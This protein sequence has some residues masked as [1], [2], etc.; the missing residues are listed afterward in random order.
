MP[1]CFLF[2]MNLLIGRRNVKEYLQRSSLVSCLM[3]FG[4][5]ERHR[6]RLLALLHWQP[7]KDALASAAGLFSNPKPAIDDQVLVHGVS[8]VAS[9]RKKLYFSV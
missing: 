6:V 7:G 4:H 8:S 2:T 9:G 5:R 1:M 3:A